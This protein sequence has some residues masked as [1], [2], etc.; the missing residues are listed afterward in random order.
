MITPRATRLVRSAGLG[1]F[2]QAL[3][4]L[5]CDGD[6]LAA[7]DRLV[8]VPT[9]AAAAHLLR[10]IENRRAAAAGAVLLPD[11]VIPAELPQRFADRIA[12]VPA[13]V[14]PARREVLMGVACR[15]AIDQGAAPP[16]RLRPG[17][18]AEILGFYDQLRRNR[19]DVDTFERIA[20]GVLEP[21]AESDRGA[22]RLVRQTRFLA[23]AFRE[24]ERHAAELGWVDEHAMRSRAIASPAPR[25]WRHVIVAVGDRVRDPHGLFAADWD[26]LA[27]VPGL[28]RLDI[29]VTDL[30]LAGSFHERVHDLLPG[31]EEVRVEAPLAPSPRLRVPPATPGPAPEYTG[32]RAALQ[33]QPLCWTARDREEEVAGFARWSREAIRTGEVTALDRMA[34]VVRQPLPYVYLAREVLRSAGL[35]LQTFD[36]LP[37]AGEPYAAAIDLVCSLVSGN[38]ARVSAVALLRSPHFRFFADGE[39]LRAASIAALDR[40][41]SAA[42]YLGELDAL[43]RIAAGWDEAPST[44]GTA[45][46]AVPAATV[47]LAI[48]RELTPLRS[49]APIGQALAVLL[50]FLTRHENLPGPDDPLRTRQLRARAAVL[51]LLT[52]LRDAHAELDPAPAEFD[53]AAAL[54]RRW[55]ESHTF[56]PRSGDTGV[57]LVDAES[58]RFGD[59]DCVQLAGLVDG[60]W[61]ER[62]RRNVFYSGAILRDLG[63]PAESERLDGARAAFA[64]LLGLPSAQL[65]LSTFTLED[66]GVVAG[67]TLLDEIERIG[68]DR[69][70]ASPAIPRIFEYEALG[71]EPVRIGALSDARQADARRRIDMREVDPSRYRGA[72]SGHTAT[73]YSLSALERYQ[74]CPFKFFA[75]DV[76]RIEETPGDETSL[77][78]RARGRFIHEVFQRFFEAWD[79]RAAVAGGGST[80]TPGRFDDARALFGEVA[81]EMLARLPE[82]DAGLERTRLFGSAI[83]TG[84]VDLVLGIEAAR[85]VDV[86]ERWLEYRMEG[87]FALS[88]SDGRLVPLKGVADRIDLLEGNRLRVIDYK[89]GYAPDPKRALQVPVYALCAQERLSARDGSSWEVAEAA[90]VAFSGKRALVP[91]VRAGAADRDAVLGAA[92]GRLLDVL[93]GVGRG[94]FPPRPHEPRI[95]SYCAYASVCRKDYVGDE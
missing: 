55:I 91:V 41:L 5:A 1:A 37:L 38:F 75:A 54:V 68:F 22:E 6:P 56:A 60:E 93:D 76:L 78:P 7:R 44:R 15:R 51:G 2:R 17:L 90:Y 65:A 64:D 32:G 47:L 42:G 50:G 62:P 40:A 85:P 34:L 24:L 58:A 82:A 74:D 33:A 4:S 35:A 8:I 87:E 20:L 57:H 3:V 19:K 23:A 26:L 48:G 88:G 94:E 80:I 95:C 36:A 31:I 9:R 25:P 30:A 69:V 18:L 67:S 39:P 84:I 89:S 73:A 92:R 86:R 72:T 16:F 45:T 71:L 66:D 11:F 83:S 10:A 77:S 61:P 43:E 29:V 52:S 81:G 14:D 28:D 79:A 59:F 21:G 12:E 53:Q 27:R 13:A 46:R 49:P 63:W 70:E